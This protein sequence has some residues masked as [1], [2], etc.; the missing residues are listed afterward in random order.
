MRNKGE[1]SG[2]GN[3]TNLRGRVHRQETRQGEVEECCSKGCCLQSRKEGNRE[4]SAESGGEPMLKLKRRI[5]LK[6]MGTRDQKDSVFR[7]RNERGVI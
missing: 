3:N 2:K 4:D 5:F 6:R 1:S 7:G